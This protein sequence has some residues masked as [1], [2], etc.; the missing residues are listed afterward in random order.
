MKKSI[1]LMLALY[2]SAVAIAQDKKGVSR[3]IPVYGDPRSFIFYTPGASGGTLP[4]IIALHGN[5]A[6]A[7]SFES[8][9]GLNEL[10]YKEKFMVIYP[11]GCHETWN[12][13][14]MAPVG[15]IKN[16]CN[17]LAFLKELVGYA[18]RECHAD[19]DNV[20]LFGFSRGGAMALH[21]TDTLASLFRGMALVSTSLT[22]KRAAWF[23]ARP[24]LPL[25]LI[26]GTGDPTIPYDGGVSKNSDLNK[27]YPYSP[28]DSL[29]QAFR[30]V[31]G[32]S[33]APEEQDI[34][35]KDKEDG[36]T[37]QSFTWKSPINNAEF[38][39]IRVEGGGH[40]IPGCGQYEGKRYIGTVSNDFNACK[41][42]LDFFKRNMKQ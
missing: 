3:S 29:M 2:F 33:G 22:T 42:A 28:T 17:D 36:T 19:K 41:A 30:A 13:P 8:Y 34:P 39:L 12:I 37:A 35:N 6:R 38:Q 31:N 11:Q 40:G 23:K 26:N 20:F 14:G 24:G 4:L 15:D 10:A 18:V 27:N 16:T 25:L 21:L 1:F 5:G 32:C 7:K 9:T